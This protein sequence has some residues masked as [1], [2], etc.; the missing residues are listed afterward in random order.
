MFEKLRG[1]RCG[2]SE[3]W[4]ALGSG[5]SAMAMALTL[6][7]R[8]DSDSFTLEYLYSCS[9][10]SP[11]EEMM[12]ESRERLAIRWKSKRGGEMVQLLAQS[13]HAVNGKETRSEWW[14]EAGLQD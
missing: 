10:S 12:D 14:S 4:M 6:V 9:R 2:G 7:G 1:S 5:A 11:S 13:T 8:G 3:H